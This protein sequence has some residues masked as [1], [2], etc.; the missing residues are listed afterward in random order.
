MTTQFPLDFT[1]ARNRREAG[2]QSSVEH[3][4]SDA[5]GWADRAF[6]ALTQ[7]AKE[8]RAPFTIESFRWWAEA[9]GLEHPPE[10]RA[11]GGITQRAMKRGVI[12]RVGYAPAASSNGSPKATYACRAQ[13]AA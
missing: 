6:D 5:P 4:N 7:Y 1:S 2:M 11:Y 10:S 8:Q 13:A 3:A 9:R 12:V